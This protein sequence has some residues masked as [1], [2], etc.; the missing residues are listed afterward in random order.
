MPINITLEQAQ[1]IWSERMNGRCVGT[2]P[3]KGGRAWLDGEFQLDELEA[4]CVI[5]RH[6]AGEGAQGAEE[7]VRDREESSSPQRVV[8]ANYSS[9]R[10]AVSVAPRT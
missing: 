8:L 10:T 9:T 2:S 7:L 6:Q 1:E 4:L 3:S 5:I